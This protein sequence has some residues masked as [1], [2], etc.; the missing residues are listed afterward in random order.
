MLD[1][2][3]GKPLA[4]VN[5][6]A[7][8][9]NTIGTTTDIDGKFQLSIQQPIGQLHFSCVGY[10][11][12]TLT[13][14]KP[15]VKVRMSAASI[16]LSEITVKAGDNPA[17]RII[18]NAVENRKQNNPL[19]LASFAYESYNKL[20]FSVDA[21]KLD[22]IKRVSEDTSSVTKTKAF[23]EKQHIFLIE[24]VN[25]RNYRKPDN[26]EKV[27][28]SR[29]SGFSDPNLALMA[30]QLQSFSFYEDYITLGDKKFLNPIT[31]GSTRKYFFNLEDTIYSGSDT[32]FVISY[33]PKKGSNFDGLRGLLYIH[34]D[35]WAIQQVK[36][37]ATE[38][39]GIEIHVQ[40]RYEK[41][42]SVW[43][44]VQLNTDLVLN[45]TKIS[46]VP[47]QG[48]GRSYL[49]NIRIN[50]IPSNTPFSRY[51]LEMDE[52]AVRKSDNEW[53]KYRVDSLSPRDLETYRVID[54]LGKANNF[55]KK[56]KWLTALSTARLNMG[57]VD[58]DLTKIASANDYEKIRVG[59][60]LITSKR[61]SKKYS[62]GGYVAYGIADRA[63]KYGLSQEITLNK[64]N[65]WV[66]AMD[67][68]YD[69][70]ESGGSQVEVKP[71]A[72]IGESLRRVIDFTRDFT[73]RYRAMF[74]IRAFQYSQWQ[75]GF[76]KQD[77]RMVDQYFFTTFS[78]EL[79]SSANTFSFNEAFVNLRFAYRERFIKSSAIEIN[80]GT[81]FPILYLNTSRGISV[82]EG[83]FASQYRYWRT[84][85]RIEHSFFIRNMGK[86]SY[87][88]TGGAVSSNI[89][90]NRLFAGRSSWFRYPIAMQNH[91]ETMHANEFVADRYL[92]FFHRHSFGSLLFKTKWIAPELI[93][94]NNIGFGGLSHRNL[95]ENRTMRSYE[96]G[97][98]ET[99]LLV[100]NI[101]KVNF[102]GYG[103]GIYYRYGAYQRT[104]AIEN[105]AF[106]LSLTLNL[107]QR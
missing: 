54:S 52:M 89:P 37:A 46:G 13:E 59:V 31:P 12:L 96:H 39:Q 53:A 77:I 51:D 14:V 18:K 6:W 29:V 40:Q 78:N 94:I 95:H 97:F 33:V 23:F 4:F 10:K 66:L 9:D 106:K 44:P 84:E 17:H 3:S 67:Y 27:I 11:K 26:N 80:K 93:L 73:T 49:S 55:D 61:F 45:N 41:I 88:I 15:Y 83:F 68:T 85:L 65:E 36:A 2:A 74:K 60:G 57:Y 42:N 64:R 62:L 30:G 63:I 43:F 103:V 21:A 56:L 35:R 92:A 76:S 58:L 16:A 72:L 20:Y 101:L 8:K 70:I 50:D 90:Y 25:E 105:W 1:S 100:N 24:T 38:K 99:G 7:N 79:P 98:F 5:V 19:N 47:L 28:A 71:S 107:E 102:L 104:K 75:L 82:S 91:F 22:S 81:K 34:T 32:V 48:F 86:Q 87:C 69:L